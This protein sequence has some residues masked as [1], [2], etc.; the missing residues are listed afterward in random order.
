ML[1]AHTQNIYIYSE[2]GPQNIYIYIYIYIY[3][4]WVWA[5]SLLLFCYNNCTNALHCYVMRTLPVLLV[6]YQY[7]ENDWMAWEMQD[8]ITVMLKI[9]V[10]RLTPRMK[11]LRWLGT[12]V[13][14]ANRHAVTYRTLGYTWTCIFKQTF[15]FLRQPSARGGL[16]LASQFHLRR[17]H[18]PRG[19]LCH[20]NCVPQRNSEEYMFLIF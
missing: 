13:T 15:P 14:V 7:S 17:R 18:T 6:I 2:C 11:A 19:R 20:K 9:I 4:F 1:Q 3:I 12:S 5:C 16:A 10:V 8:L